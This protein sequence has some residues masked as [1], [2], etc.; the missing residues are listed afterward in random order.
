MTLTK[1]QKIL[2]GIL[3]LGLSVLAVD[4]FV[5]SSGGTGPA[6]ATASSTDAAEVVTA[7]PI[8]DVKALVA[9]AATQ[10]THAGLASRLSDF[11]RHHAVDPDGV[12]DAFAPSPAWVP[13]TTD[14]SP[15]S[16]AAAEPASTAVTRFLQT[17]QLVAVMGG[18]E[19]RSASVAIINGKTLRLGQSI[20]GFRLVEVRRRSA[21]LEPENPA[22]AGLQPGQ[23][24]ELRVMTRP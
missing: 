7:N 3:A 19:G 22:A 21:L 8:S 13:P 12:R 9:M 24:I 18:G 14:A 17:H 16:P 23:R 4:R 1:Q 6:T 15:T 11:A 10:Q 2:G 5:L 20:S